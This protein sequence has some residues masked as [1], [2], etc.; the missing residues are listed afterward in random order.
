MV[1]YV[2]GTFGGGVVITIRDRG[3][4]LAVCRPSTQSW[5]Q[6]WEGSYRSQYLESIGEKTVVKEHV[7]VQN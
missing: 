6:N 1:A 5:S 3:N 7:T 2:I 4:L